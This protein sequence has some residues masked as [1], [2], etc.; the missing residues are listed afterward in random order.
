MKHHLCTAIL[1]ITAI[2]VLPGSNLFAQDSEPTLTKIARTGEFVIDHRADSSPLSY[3]NGD[4]EPS[5]Y[6]V[7]CKI[8]KSNEVVYRSNS[9]A[10][11]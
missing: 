4:G 6:S 11:R 5:G 7:N 9:C 3:E 10:V 2:L 1:L 8:N